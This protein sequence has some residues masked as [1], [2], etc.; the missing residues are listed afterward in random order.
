MAML[1]LNGLVMNT[2]MTSGATD[3]TT[4][5][6][7]QP[8]SK[9]QVLCESALRNG[10]MRMELVTLTVEDVRPYEALKGRQVR[11]P[12]GAFAVGGGVQYFALRGQKP[13]ELAQVA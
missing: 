8:K 12:V 5:E 2:F 7:F 4:G 3:K 10:E 6:V 11:V 13:D 9:V 1:T